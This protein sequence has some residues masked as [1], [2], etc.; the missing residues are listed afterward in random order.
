MT[1]FSLILQSGDD[2]IAVPLIY[3]EI[4]ILMLTSFVIGYFFAFFSQKSKYL[5]KITLLRKR[6]ELPDQEESYFPDEEE[7]EEL[8]ELVA[9][10]TTEESTQSKNKQKSG[11]LDFER[12]GYAE[13]G[14]ADDLQKII[15][16][17]PYTEEKLNT[18]GI[19]TFEQISRFN[20]SDIELVTELIQFFPDRIKNDHWVSKAK[21][22]LESKRRS[23]LRRE[24]PRMK[25]A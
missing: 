4:F 9:I 18:I 13:A 5:K 22:L 14:E 17:G 3:I 12:L 16:I 7:D 2:T 1:A 8:E 20:D 11:V 21:M 23:Q 25:K 24:G 6:G 10:Q 15:G 19:Y